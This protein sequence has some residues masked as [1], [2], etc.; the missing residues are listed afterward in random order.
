MGSGDQ[1]AWPRMI[2]RLKSSAE[3]PWVQGGR[4]AVTLANRL[5]ASGIGGAGLV[6][7][8]SDLEAAEAA[9]QSLRQEVNRHEARLDGAAVQAGETMVN[10][11]NAVAELAGNREQL[12]EGG[13]ADDAM[14]ADLDFQIGMLEKRIAEVR[15][16]QSSE[17]RHI[18]KDLSPERDRLVSGELQRQ[19]VTAELIRQIFELKPDPCP[20]ELQRDYYALEYLQQSL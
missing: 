6:K 14:L 2:D 11:R 8:V 12:V 9:V 16:D 15:A 3:D 20:P 5:T 1:E 10:L 18:E 13:L 4:V 7:L 19:T 17:N